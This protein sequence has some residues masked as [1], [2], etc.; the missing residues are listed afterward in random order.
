MTSLSE[1]LQH[2]V[3]PSNYSQTQKI[4]PRLT[5][6]T[7]LCSNENTHVERKN[8]NECTYVDCGLH[9]FFLFSND[10]RSNQ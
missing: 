2:I 5:L 8:F 6:I 9:N 4:L 10:K 7:K 1:S 3:V